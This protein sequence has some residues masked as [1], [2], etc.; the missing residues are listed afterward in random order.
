MTDFKALSA[1]FNPDEVSWRVGTMKK[2]KTGAMALAYIDARVVMDRLDSACGPDGWQCRYSH[3]GVTTVC[4]IAV[5]CGDDWLWKADG[6]GQSD[7]EAEKG[8]LSDAFKRAAVRWG[9]GRY[10]YELPSPWVEVDE[11]KKIKPPEMKRLGQILREHTRALLN[12]A[13]QA[14]GTTKPENFAPE[15]RADGLTNETRSTYQVEKDK[16]LALLRD[17]ALLAIGTS[18]NR[19]QLAMWWAENRET[20]KK[21]LG[22]DDYVTV[23]D[24][25]LAK[26]DALPELAV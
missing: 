19:A 22:D 15:A 1:P 16:K 14:P 9:V 26:R 24:A 13:P 4:D 10:L 6:A 8:S 23:Y 21:K 12:P 25:V 17:S 11:W 7:I 2:D 3:V 18:E 5:R 20:L